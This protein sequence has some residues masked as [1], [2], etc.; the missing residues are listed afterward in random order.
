MIKAALWHLM[1][2]LWL[3]GLV[4]GVWWVWPSVERL[5]LTGELAMS[6]VWLMIG[7]AAWIF[8]LNLGLRRY[9]RR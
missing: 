8:A 3:V 6:L 5:Q 1:M 7:A 2:L 4:Y 9:W